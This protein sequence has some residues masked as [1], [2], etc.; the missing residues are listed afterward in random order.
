VY[1]SWNFFFPCENEKQPTESS[2]QPLWSENSH[3]CWRFPI[4]GRDRSE[5]SHKW[6]RFPIVGRDRKWRSKKERVSLSNATS[7]SLYHSLGVAPPSAIQRR[8]EEDP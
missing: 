1:V 7:G 5:N 2:L 8:R 3:K 6:W 4:V